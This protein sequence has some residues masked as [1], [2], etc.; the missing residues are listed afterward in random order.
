MMAVDQEHRAVPGPCNRA[1]QSKEESH[2]MSSLNI[3]DV[4]Y[5]TVAPVDRPSRLGAR[6]VAVSATGRA[7]RPVR[8]D[9]I[10]SSP[11]PEVLDAIGAASHAFDSLAAAGRALQFAIDDQ[12]RKVSIS[13]H[14]TLGSVLATISPSRML[15]VVASGQID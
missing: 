4:A 3:A 10:P 9:M 2:I 8:G 14:D 5:T 6:T 12:T 1:R 15:D 7:D 13:V 11:P